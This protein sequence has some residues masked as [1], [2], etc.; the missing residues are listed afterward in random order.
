MTENGTASERLLNAAMRIWMLGAA[1]A[2]IIITDSNLRISGWNRWL[3]EQTG[4]RSDDV[5]G[6]HLFELYPELV[7]RE[8][9]GHYLRA[10]QGQVSILSQRLHLY[11]IRIPVIS[12][13]K[14]FVYMQQRARIS[15]LIDGGV[16]IGTL[17]V[18][19]DVT[20]RVVR[21]LQLQAQVEARSALLASEKAAREEAEAANRLKGR[22]PRNSLARASH[23]ADGDYRLV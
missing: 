10:L 21:E 22:V 19:E 16:V 8:L 23:T 20:E 12:E 17:T 2:G 3:E 4:R 7:E 15:P 11:L 13:N 14:E 6:Q 9:D 1:Q 5:N 18:I